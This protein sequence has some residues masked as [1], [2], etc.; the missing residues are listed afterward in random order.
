MAWHH[1]SS[2]VRYR[3]DGTTFWRISATPPPVSSTR[4]NTHPFL[5][6]GRIFAHNGVVEGLDELDERLESVGAR[7]LVLGQTDSNGSSP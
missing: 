3:S 2:P 5:Q 6:D 4:V 7:D 1:R